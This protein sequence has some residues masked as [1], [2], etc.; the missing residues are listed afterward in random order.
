M[1]VK[2]YSKRAGHEGGMEATISLP[3]GK[4]L[5]CAGLLLI[6]ADFRPNYHCLSRRRYFCFLQGQP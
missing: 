3:M 1:A 2:H 4:A 6:T 5:E